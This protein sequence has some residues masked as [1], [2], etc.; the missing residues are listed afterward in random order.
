ME[1]IRVGVLTSVRLFVWAAIVFFSFLFLAFSD[2]ARLHHYLR[3]YSVSLY[4]KTSIDHRI[5]AAEIE[6]VVIYQALTTV[7]NILIFTDTYVR[8]A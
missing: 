7:E 6:C 3:S 5:M 1:G 8:L 4:V 2:F